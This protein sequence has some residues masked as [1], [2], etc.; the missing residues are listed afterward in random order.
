[1]RVFAKLGKTYCSQ[2]GGT[3]LGKV[4]FL[5]EGGLAFSKT[6]VTHNLKPVIYYYDQSGVV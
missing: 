6:A 2:M 1:M 3:C 5:R 4:E